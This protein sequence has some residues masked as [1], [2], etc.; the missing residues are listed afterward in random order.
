MTNSYTPTIN[1]IGLIEFLNSEKEWKTANA[2]LKDYVLFFVNEYE[3]T[4]D[5][6]IFGSHIMKTNIGLIKYKNN[7][8]DNDNFEE[9]L[10][11]T[12]EDTELLN[13]KWSEILTKIK[14][15]KVTVHAWLQDG[16]PLV[17]SDNVVL[18]GFK[19][20]IHKETSEKPQNMSVIENVISETYKK[21]YKVRTVLLREYNEI[22]LKPKMCFANESNEEVINNLE[23][24]ELEILNSD[25]PIL[26]CKV[27]SLQFDRISK[28]ITDVLNNKETYINKVWRED[29][30]NQFENDVNEIVEELL[31]DKNIFDLALQFV[32]K[33]C[34][35]IFNTSS[36]IKQ[37]E[38]LLYELV[39]TA[40]VKLLAVGTSDNLQHL[41]YEEKF[42]VTR[43]GKFN[44]SKLIE[45]FYNNYFLKFVY[46][47]GTKH[48]YID[49]MQDDEELDYEA[50]GML[51]YYHRDQYAV[52]VIIRR[53]LIILFAEKAQ[54]T[55]GL[56]EAKLIESTTEEIIQSYFEDATIDLS[57]EEYRLQLLFLL[58]LYK[59]IDVKETM[60]FE[61]LKRLI[62]LLQKMQK[63][64][65]MDDFELM[66][67][68]NE[69]FDRITIDDVDLMSGRQFEEFLCNIFAG[70]G[71][72]CTLTKLSGDQG[73]DI[74]L[75]KN[76]Y[77]IGVQSKCYST[78][79]GNK[80]IQEVT[81]GLNHYGLDKGI[82]VTNNYFTTSAIELANSNKVSLW[83]RKVLAD[84]INQFC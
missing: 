53:A 16:Q 82:V 20:K 23:E 32:K 24:F 81:A 27:T 45:S 52:W 67:M 33:T 29:I 79:V 65:S 25:V 40:G 43:K 39:S 5:Y 73:I 83:D 57:Q 84:K 69:L 46:L 55:S 66:L 70:M 35:N 36:S 7:K 48:I 8:V 37:F 31:T 78:A 6:F 22:I 15:E 38:Y 54:K 44:G 49:V 74:I 11:Y 41:T 47:I 50:K 62:E 10:D 77:K 71:Y 9:N 51:E 42:Q 13:S 26:R 63:K 14:E 60:I 76:G 28:H 17:A 19:N 1:N 18:V 58:M 61:S 34:I 68:R 12:I 56:S 30:P 75:E 2:V 4:Q 72:K 21:K 80:A 64:K 3:E 59:K